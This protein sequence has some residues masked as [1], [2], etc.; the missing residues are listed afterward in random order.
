IGVDYRA[1][2][3]SKD[4]GGAR[5]ADRELSFDGRRTR[6]YELL[7]RHRHVLLVP[8][9]APVDGLERFASHL[10]IA[11]ADVERATLVR[12]DGYIA[13]RAR[14]TGLASLVP[15][16]QIVLGGATEMRHLAA[17]P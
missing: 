5:M 11:E 7:R 9:G 15:Y 8:V 14:G 4:G 1:S 2:G 10:T 17:A 3:P 16:L 12:P 6:L 13:G